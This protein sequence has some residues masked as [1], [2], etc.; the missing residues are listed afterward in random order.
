MSLAIYPTERATGLILTK[1]YP[2]PLKFC[3]NSSFKVEALKLREFRG[4]IWMS[5]GEGAIQKKKPMGLI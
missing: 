5:L 2:N 4:S 1:N 3:K